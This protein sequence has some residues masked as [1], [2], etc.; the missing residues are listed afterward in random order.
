MSAAP[1]DPPVSSA[2]ALNAAQADLNALAA[3]I[4]NPSL[5]G[6]QRADLLQNLQAASTQLGGPYRGQQAGD[7]R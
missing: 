7:P 3:G 2:D 6:D 5:N 1:S 4:N